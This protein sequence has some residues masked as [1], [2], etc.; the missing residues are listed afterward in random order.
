MPKKAKLLASAMSAMRTTKVHL[1]LSL[2]Y[3]IVCSNLKSISVLHLS[4]SSVIISSHVVVGE[5]KTTPALMD[6]EVSRSLE[7]DEEDKPA[8]MMQR[9]HSLPT[10]GAVSLE[11]CH[12]MLLY[13]E[14]QEK[15]AESESGGD[16]GGFNDIPT[17]VAEENNGKYNPKNKLVDQRGWGRRGGAS[18]KLS[19][20]GSNKKF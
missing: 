5:K 7:Q 13:L 1:T 3:K 6:L 14:P 16:K 19:S 2:F 17:I 11:R 8:P 18:N 4:N 15:V 9:T 12:R 20:E 10:R